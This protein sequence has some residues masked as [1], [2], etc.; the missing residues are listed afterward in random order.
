MKD[1]LYVAYLI[2]IYVPLLL[3][4]TVVLGVITIIGCYLCGGYFFGYYPGRWWARLSTWSALLWVEVEGREK[5][6]K[7]KSY[8]FVGNHSSQLDIFMVYGFLNVNFK[9]VMKRE[10][11]KIPI[12]GHACESAGHI[13][14]DR[15]SAK[16]AVNTIEKAKKILTNGVSVVIFPE[17]SRSPSGRMGRFKRGAFALAQELHLELVPMTLVGANKAMPRGDWRIYRNKMKLVIHDPISTEGLSD[18]NL[19][20]Y[21]ATTYQIIESALPK[22]LRNDCE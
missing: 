8:I 10:L 14:V 6:Q 15:T 9:W 3:I 11:R 20:E 21:M 22:E 17:G 13:F 4:Y 7:G 16:S 5:L 19:S 1:A 2:C 18:E 12:L